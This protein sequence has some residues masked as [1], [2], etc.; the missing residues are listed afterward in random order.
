MENNWTK[1]EVCVS[2]TLSG[3]NIRNPV[4]FW[5]FQ[6]TTRCFLQHICSLCLGDN[7]I[8]TV[9]KVQVGLFNIASFH[10]SP[11]LNSF[12]LRQWGNSPSHAAGTA[13]SPFGL[14]SPLARPADSTSTARKISGKEVGEPSFFLIPPY[15]FMYLSSLC[16]IEEKG[17]PFFPLNKVIFAN[18][19]FTAS[20]QALCELPASIWTGDH[21]AFFSGVNTDSLPVY[22]L[23]SLSPSSSPASVFHSIMSHT[24]STNSCYATWPFLL[25]AV[26]IEHNLWL[27]AGITPTCTHTHRQRSLGV[28][29]QSVGEINRF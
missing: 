6:H 21:S 17:A 19:E 1:P 12:V 13:S 28:H 3:E 9:L 14:I 5:Q 11:Q 24:H 7:Y 15:V 22:P 23:L 27:F 10:V 26:D 18:R 2:F 8:S 4:C 25:S 20:L 29:L 16:R